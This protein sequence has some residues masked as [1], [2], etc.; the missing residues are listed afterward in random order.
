MGK[1]QILKAPNGYVVNNAAEPE[2]MSTRASIE[3][4]L[5]SGPNDEARAM[6]YLQML[7]E[8]AIETHEEEKEFHDHGWRD[9]RDL[10]DHSLLSAAKN[11]IGAFNTIYAAKGSV[12]LGPEDLMPLVNAVAFHEEDQHN[13]DVLPTGGG[14]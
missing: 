10:K 11:F 8:Q 7:E 4:A 12:R 13:P 1:H 3:S 2:I 14:E 9:L 5:F 6:V